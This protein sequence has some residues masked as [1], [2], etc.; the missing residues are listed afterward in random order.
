MYSKYHLLYL[1]VP[2]T[3]L[4]IGK[5]QYVNNVYD[6]RLK[7]TVQIYQKDSIA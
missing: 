4:E 6:L 7:G 1:L 5:G 3:L 2:F